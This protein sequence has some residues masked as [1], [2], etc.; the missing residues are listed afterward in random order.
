MVRGRANSKVSGV[1]RILRTLRPTAHI[2]SASELQVAVARLATAAQRVG[3]C[4]SGSRGLTWD[5]RAV[6]VT[7][8]IIGVS[9]SGRLARSVSVCVV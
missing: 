8:D 3:A 6:V 9:N 2:H 4:L 5:E 7:S 1:R